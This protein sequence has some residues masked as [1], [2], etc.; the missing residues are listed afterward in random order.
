M[1]S[2]WERLRYALS[3]AD[4]FSVHP[5]A[6]STTAGVRRNSPLRLGPQWATVSASTLPG[7][8]SSSSLA[9]LIVIE[10]R[11]SS[12]AGRVAA[13]PLGR[14]ASR[15][16]LRYRSIVEALI[17]ISSPSACPSHSSSSP[18]SRSTGSHCGSIA[19]RYLPHGMSINTHT[20]TS[21]CRDWPE[22]RHG[23]SRAD[24]TTPFPCCP[25]WA[26]RRLAVLLPT[27]SVSHILSRMTPFCFF[28]ALTYSSLNLRV[29]CRFVVMLIP[30]S[31][32]PAKQT[33]P[34]SRSL[35]MRH[36]Y[37]IRA[38]KT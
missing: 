13:N 7:R 30:S 12:P 10:L 32:R 33:D 34:V 24:G 31:I 26:G 29:T 1:A 11:D 17:A 2:A 22:Y 14:A 36:H 8:P 3:R 19:L 38:Q 27:P 23:R 35:P 21:S 5:V 28:D 37:T 4:A 20:R 16:G 15:T 18:Q 25:A 9:F 6:K